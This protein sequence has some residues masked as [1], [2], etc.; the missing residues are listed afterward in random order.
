MMKG[1][2][3]NREDLQVDV[4]MLEDYALQRYGLRLMYI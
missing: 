3:I 2:N 4:G 1:N